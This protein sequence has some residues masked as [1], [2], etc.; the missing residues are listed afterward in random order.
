MTG[1][2][3]VQGAGSDL[4]LRLAREL[5]R[6][7]SR[8]NSRP[9]NWSDLTRMQVNG[10]LLGLRVALGMALGHKAASTEVVPAA[11][12]FYREWLATGVTA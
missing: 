11:E 6:R 10:E 5:H 4:V 2:A 12:Q 7:Q 3:N 1:A 8:Y 9:A